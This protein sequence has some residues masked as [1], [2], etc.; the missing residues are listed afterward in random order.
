M[1]LSRGG[2]WLSGRLLHPSAG[3]RG[4]IGSTPLWAPRTAVPSWSISI[5]AA[6]SASVVY[7]WQVATSK[8]VRRWLGW[9]KPST[10][11]PFSTPEGW[12][13]G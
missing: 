2:A 9:P 12:A 3:F 6:S 5:S 10:T 4:G 11:K 13:A 1:R 7:A 8:S